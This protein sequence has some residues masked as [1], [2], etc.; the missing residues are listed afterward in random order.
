MSRRIEIREF[1]T[2]PEIALE[3]WNPNACSG[4]DYKSPRAK[5]L[6]EALGVDPSD[7]EY[8]LAANTDG[9]WALIGLTVAGHRYAVEVE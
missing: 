1:S 2:M 7:E 5:A 8:A 9:R 6:L 4:D 3:G